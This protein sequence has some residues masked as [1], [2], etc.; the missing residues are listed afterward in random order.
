MS[1]CLS[2]HAK[3]ENCRSVGLIDVT[4]YM[5]YAVNPTS[6]LFMVTFELDF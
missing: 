1:V 4:L 2:V 6:E 3:T 5:L